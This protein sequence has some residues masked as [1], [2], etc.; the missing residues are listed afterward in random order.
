[1]AKAVIICV[2]DEPAVL[3]SLRR[4]L[5]ETFEDQCDLETVESSEET[6][7]LVQELIADRCQIALV[8]ADYLMPGLRGDE[9]LRQIHRQSPETLTVM[10]TGQAEVDGITNAINHARLYRYI[11]KPWD[12]ADLQLTVREA[13][14][15]F[16]QAQQLTEYHQTLEQK[17]KARTQELS[18]ALESLRQAQD[19]LIRSEKMSALGNLVAG[20]A[21]EINTPVGNAILASSV[22]A[23]ETETF[24]TDCQQKQL[25]RSQLQDY[26][27]TAHDSS[28]LIVSNLQQADRLIRSFKQVAVDQSAHHWRCFNVVDYLNSI[29]R[30][31]EPQL[32]RSKHQAQISGDADIKLSSFPGAISQVITNFVMNSLMHAYLPGERGNIQIRVSQPQHDHI[33]LTYSDDGQGISLEY[34]DRIFEP[35]FTTARE[36][37]G[38][39]LGLHIAHNLVTQTLQ[40][41]IQL[42]SEK[43]DGITFTLTL[44]NLMPP[45]QGCLE[46]E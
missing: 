45:D 11:A 34:R 30:N 16:F 25:K 6:L 19:E 23:N 9:V 1:M 44:P 12:S 29:L 35:F 22:L 46:N 5:S 42:A 37:G 15:S 36:R 10:L 41:S 39:G 40:G 13:L 27:K 7:E 4:E 18:E 38:S 8:I 26:L 14:N 3:E 32:K 17:V 33:L 21:H 31:L 43:G 24:S 20:V 2:D 28:K